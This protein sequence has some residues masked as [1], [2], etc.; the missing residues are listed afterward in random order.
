MVGGVGTASTT[1]DFCSTTLLTTFL[2]TESGMEHA[3]D[4]NPKTAKKCLIFIPTTP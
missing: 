3:T 4:N 2:G 1:V